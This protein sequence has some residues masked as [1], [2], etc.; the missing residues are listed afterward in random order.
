MAIDKLE[1]I[2]NNPNKNNLVILLQQ[3]IMNKKITP[4]S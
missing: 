4:I 2:K 3:L 1:A